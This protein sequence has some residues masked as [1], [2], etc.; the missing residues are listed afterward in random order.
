MQTHWSL[1][2][3]A[4]RLFPLVLI[5]AAFLLSSGSLQAQTQQTTDYPPLPSPPPP[6]TPK[7]PTTNPY[8][9]QRNPG[10]GGDTNSPPRTVGTSQD[11]SKKGGHPADT[12]PGTN[13]HSSTMGPGIATASIA[14]GLI[15]AKNIHDYNKSPEKLGHDGPQVPKSLNMNGF[16]IKGLAY[17]NWPVVLD[18]KLD[19]PG[20]VEMDIVA[21]DNHRD[22][23]II[24]NL[25]NRRA[26]AIFK[27]P[28]NFGDKL[29]TAIYQVR[30][31]PNPGAT[32]PAPN[33]RTYGIGAG[34]KAVGSVAID[35]LTFQPATIH[36]HAHE[37]ASFGFHAHSAFDGVRA[38]F[39]F[40]TLLNGQVLVQ[41]D[42]EQRLS[43]V[44]EGERAKG[45]WQGNG[46]PGEHMLQIRA[47]RGL[48]NGGD[49]VVAWSPDIVDVVK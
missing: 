37:A 42:Q 20:G 28:A 32:S 18:F 12:R 39:I 3:F 8:P 44:P 11:P 4:R 9:P 2:S 15:F 10:K 49:W 5:Q 16:T 46:R 25:P 24:P 1:K 22:Q 34:E 6:A 14:A 17:P 30:S 27:L 33:L 47:W 48:Q 43:P 19:S 40:T 31:I 29:Q 26:Y 21:A 38:E 45:T 35:Q 13:P 36:P 7:P 23:V 41:Q